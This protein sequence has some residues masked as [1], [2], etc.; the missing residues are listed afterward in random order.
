MNDRLSEK[1]KAGSAVTSV[2]GLVS[3]HFIFLTDVIKKFNTIILNFIVV[4]TRLSSD[5]TM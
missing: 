2:I 1:L 5:D 3:F 4:R